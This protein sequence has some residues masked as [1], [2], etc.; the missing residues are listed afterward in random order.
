M[1]LIRGALRL[2]SHV[3]A[4]D[5]G[6]LASQMVGRLLPHQGSPA[7]QRFTG[8]VAA[9]A[10]ACWLRPLRPA[11]H[12]PGTELVRTLEGHSGYISG[13][14]VTPDGRRAVSASGDHTL[15]VRYGTWSPV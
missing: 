11:L 2:S 9:V 1:E 10:P 3:L 7:I 15:K 8:E 13:V 6:Q 14:A 4:A 12:P 5:A